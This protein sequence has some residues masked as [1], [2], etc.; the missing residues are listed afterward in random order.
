MI[1]FV[2]KNIVRGITS[3]DIYYGN[4]LTRCS[5]IVRSQFE[6]L[7]G[8]YR[9]EVSNGVI[10]IRHLTK[11]WR[12]GEIRVG[13]GLYGTLGC[14]MHCGELSGGI[15]CVRGNDWFESFKSQIKMNGRELVIE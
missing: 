12:M 5:V 1:R 4:E 2:K 9:L 7:K 3:Y 8:S 15:L 13:N 10:F 11:G 14:V 6:P